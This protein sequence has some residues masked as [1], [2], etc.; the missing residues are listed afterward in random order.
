MPKHSYS[1]DRSS[2]GSSDRS[3]DRSKKRNKRDSLCSHC[4]SFKKKYLDDTCKSYFETKAELK[5]INDNSIAIPSI[6]EY[7]EK[8]K[9]MF[10]ELI[11]YSLN[12]EKKDCIKIDSINNKLIIND[13]II[14]LSNIEISKYISSGCYGLIFVSSEND[15]IKYIIKFIKKNP[16]NNNEVNIMIDIRNNNTNDIPNYINIVNYHLNCNIIHNYTSNNILTG[17]DNCFKSNSYAM[18]IL[19]YFDGTIFDLIQK[20]F[21]L[22][23]PNIIITNIDI[24]YSIFAQLLLSICLFHNKFKYY[25]KDAHLKNFL[26]KKVNVNDKYSHYKI[27]ENN[28]YIKNCGYIVILSDYGKSKKIDE[29]KS[30]HNK[31]IFEDYEDIIYKLSLYKNKI[32][33]LK[34]INIKFNKDTFN[35]FLFID[36]L[37]KIYLNIKTEKTPDMELINTEPYE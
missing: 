1:T 20:L 36:E 37:M 34:N 3:S 5:Y 9:R 23:P 11:E 32:L 19:E 29:R 13:E 18:I 22:F 24:F 15:G 33:T 6:N 17:I 35:E 27:N 30:N 25:H 16:E 21:R 8:R 14:K 12:I 4:C 2:E 28:Y 31:K 26:Y 7:L 10:E